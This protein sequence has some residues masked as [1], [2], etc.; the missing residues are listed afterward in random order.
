MT[1]D[2]TGF[3][4]DGA[5]ASRLYNTALNRHVTAALVPSD[6]GCLDGHEA[7]EIPAIKTFGKAAM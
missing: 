6:R 4:E 1:G 7:S 2:F 3:W 5:T